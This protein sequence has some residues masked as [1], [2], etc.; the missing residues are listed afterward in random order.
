MVA[1]SIQSQQDPG[2]LLNVQVLFWVL[3]GTAGRAKNFNVP[4]LR[5]GHISL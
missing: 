4:L 2:T 1:Q 5:Q 3:G